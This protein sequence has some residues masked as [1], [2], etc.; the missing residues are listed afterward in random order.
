MSLFRSVQEPSRRFAQTNRNACAGGIEA[1]DNE[2]RLDIAEF[3]GPAMPGGCLPEIRLDAPPMRIEFR[4]L[5][6]GR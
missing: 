3:S 6:N 4:Q 1:T 5:D 2:L